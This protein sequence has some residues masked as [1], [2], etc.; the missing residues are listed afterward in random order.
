VD[1]TCYPKGRQGRP[2]LGDT[3]DEAHTS[4][5][6]ALLSSTD[7][8]PAGHKLFD[9]GANQH[10]TPYHSLLP[11]TPLTPKAISTATNTHSC[12]SCRSLKLD[13]PNGKSTTLIMLKEVL[14]ALDITATLISVGHMTKPD[15][16][17][18]S[19]VAH[20]HSQCERHTVGLIPARMVYTRFNTRLQPATMLC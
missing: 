4:L 17:P 19:R 13:I 18:H 10:L 15:T 2:E 8:V 20:H 3:G 12:D 7:L 16:R 1:Y 9:S 5:D 14:H 11:T 6:A